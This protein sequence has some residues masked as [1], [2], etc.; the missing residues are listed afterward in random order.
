MALNWP[1]LLAWSTKYH[2]GTAPSQFKQMSDEDREFL[3]KAME[4]AFGQI[5]DPNKVFAEALDHIRSQDRTDESICTALELIDRVCDDPDVA[6]NVEKLD[7][8]QPLLDLVKTHAGP[9]RVRT[10]EILALLLSNNPHIQTVGVKRGALQLFLGLVRDS[11]RKSEDR[12]KAFRALVA[13]IRQM[14]AY[15]DEFLTHNDGVAMLIDCLSL[16]EDARTREKA[17]SFTLSLV[18]AGRL[19]A[20]DSAPLA[21]ALAALYCDMTDQNLQYR[22]AV[23]SCAVELARMFPASCA[24]SELASAV[25]SRLAQVRRAKDKGEIEEQDVT[26]EVASLLECQEALAA[27]RPAA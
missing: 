5:E 12:S 25:Q 23:A 10:M 7:G 21:N 26:Q 4:E 19:Q 24:S 11:Q 2:D 17:A 16:E 3:E 6:R 15:E 1:G 18:G 22:E 27:A 13:L 20:S 9:I 8:M 14:E